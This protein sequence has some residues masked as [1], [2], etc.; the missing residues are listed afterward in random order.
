[1]TVPLHMSEFFLTGAPPDLQAALTAVLG[2]ADIAV[3]TDEAWLGPASIGVVQQARPPDFPVHL[4]FFVREGTGALP[5]PENLA[6]RLAQAWQVGVIWADDDPNPYQWLHVS[7]GQTV[8]RVF[9]DVQ[10]FDADSR[11]VIARRA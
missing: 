4:G 5:T 11:M 2:V 3:T 8:H 10:A 1:M 9:L 7:P 6:Q